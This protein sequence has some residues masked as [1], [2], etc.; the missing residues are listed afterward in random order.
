[1]LISHSHRVVFPRSARL[2]QCYRAWNISFFLKQV[3][4]AVR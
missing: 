1:V 3:R 4:I 2:A